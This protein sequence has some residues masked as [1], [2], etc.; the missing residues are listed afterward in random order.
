MRQMN[1]LVKA[2]WRDAVAYYDR[3]AASVVERLSHAQ[4]LRLE[5]IMH[6]AGAVVEFAPEKTGVV[7]PAE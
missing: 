6:L 4:L 1:H 3:H 7:S 2:A 5:E